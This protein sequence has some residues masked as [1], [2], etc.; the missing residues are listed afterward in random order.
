MPQ[1]IAKIEGV[2]VKHVFLNK[3]RT[4]LGRRT[5]NDIVLDNLA[6]S[7]NH[8][9]FELRGLAEVTVE[10]L[11]S[12]NGTYV[13]NQI[14]KEPQLL[15]DGDVIAIGRY[16]IQYLSSSEPHNEFSNT[17]AMRLEAAETPM[18]VQNH[19][20]RAACL[21]VLNGSSAGLEVPLVKAVTTFGKAA[22]SLVSIAQRRSG[23]FIAYLDGSDAP[24]LNDKPLGAEAIPLS[25]QDIITLSG[26]TMQFHLRG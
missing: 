20:L 8:C 7:G 13:N 15:R 6:V 5:T 26:V 17:S 2:E 9:V 14:I 11:H 18:P 10:D 24:L 21:T 12:T 22:T 3:D 19:S 25:D 4:T 1:L 23:F 16:R